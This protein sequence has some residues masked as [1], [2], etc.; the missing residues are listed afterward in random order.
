MDRRLTKVQ[1]LHPRF[2]ERPMVVAGMATMPT[3][4]ATFP[5]ALASI[6][7]QVDRL[8]LFCDR[9]DEFPDVR[10]PRV[11]PLRSQEYGDLGAAGKFLGLTMTPPGAV[12][13]GTDDDIAYPPDY[14]ATMIGHLRRLPRPGVVGVHGHRMMPNFASFVDGVVIYHRSLGMKHPAPVHLLGG[15]T[16]AFDTG[17]LRF[18]PRGWPNRNMDDLH[19]A[20]ECARRGIRRWVVPRADGWVRSLEQN[21]PDS[22][23]RAVK[24][25][26][27][28]QTRLVRELVAVDEQ[29]GGLG[30]LPG[31]EPRTEPPDPPDPPDPSA[32][33]VTPPH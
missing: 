16:V 4:S 30:P 20:L 19:L 11:V 10:H 32:P 22:I 7:P 15:D 12:Y 17:L 26:H 18:D 28:I 21:Q 2:R 25:N 6:L 24:E 5:Q 1:V 3:R 29:W 13:L 31:L 8:F 9:F 14:A 23:W 27:V 33:A